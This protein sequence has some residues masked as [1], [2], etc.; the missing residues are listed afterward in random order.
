MADGG[1]GDCPREG[2]HHLRRRTAS[3]PTRR[4]GCRHGGAT[5]MTNDLERPDQEIEAAA[6]SLNVPTPEFRR[7]G[8]VEAADIVA[9]AMAQFVEGNPRAW[10]LR[11]KRPK[12]SFVYEHNFQHLTEHIPASDL[13]CWL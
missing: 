11:L 3:G 12:K 13:R 2:Q 9:R 5:L 6:R 10:W 8:A 1:K 7:C 4:E